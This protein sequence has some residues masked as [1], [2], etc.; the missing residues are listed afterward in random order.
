MSVRRPLKFQKI[1]NIILFIYDYKC[2][3][4]GFVSVSNHVHHLDENTDNND[5]FNLVP[6]CVDC[7]KMIHSAKFKI[8]ITNVNP[9]LNELHRLNKFWF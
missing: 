3:V 7:H 2:I 1:K 8:M 6:V 9:I 5:A 4:C